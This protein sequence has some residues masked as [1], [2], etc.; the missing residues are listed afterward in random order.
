MI[1][2][3]LYP[4]IT[5]PNVRTLDLRSNVRVRGI[6]SKAVSKAV[7]EDLSSQVITAKYNGMSCYTLSFNGNPFSSRSNTQKPTLVP[8]EDI[9]EK[10]YSTKI[11]TPTELSKPQS[12][13]IEIISETD[14]LSE[15]EPPANTHEICLARQI[16]DPTIVN[17][18]PSEFMTSLKERLCIYFCDN[19]PHKN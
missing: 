16:I 3:Q 14:R 17:T 13:I 18:P 6:L 5:H 1:S 9:L 15:H 19:P 12:S 10:S 2:H 7:V 11:K 4:S 8:R